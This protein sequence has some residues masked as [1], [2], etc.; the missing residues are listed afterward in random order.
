M[1][2]LTQLTKENINKDVTKISAGVYLLDRTS[3]GTAPFNNDYVGRSD[4]DLNDRLQKHV[5]NYNWFKFEY[6]ASPKAAFELES[7]LYHD[8]KPTDNV[9]HPDRPANSGWKCPHCTIFG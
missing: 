3:K 2:S 5:G 7:K 8:Y 1:T 9:I 6:C 4:T